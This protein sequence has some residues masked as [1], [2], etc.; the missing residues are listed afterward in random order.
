MKTV[1]IYY[2]AKVGTP[3]LNGGHY[4]TLDI[5]NIVNNRPIHLGTTKYNTYSF[6]GEDIEVMNFLIDAGEIGIEN[7]DTH[8]F[9]ATGKDH[10]E[11]IKI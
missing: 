9:S 1:F 5:S 10:F 2:T 3:L 11:I 8:Y 7:R 6:R 4:V